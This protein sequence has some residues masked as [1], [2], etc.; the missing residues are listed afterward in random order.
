MVRFL[1]AVQGYRIDKYRRLLAFARRRAG[2]PIRTASVVSA[3]TGTSH[4]APFMAWVAGRIPLIAR[5]LAKPTQMPSCSAALAKL[6]ISVLTPSGSYSARPSRSRISRTRTVVQ[7]PPSPVLQR[8]RFSDTAIR[9]MRGKPAKRVDRRWREIGRVSARP[10]PGH[11]D[12]GVAPSSP[13]DQQHR[14]VGGVVEVADD[15][16]DQDVDQGIAEEALRRIQALYQIES[17]IT[18][19]PCCQPT[20]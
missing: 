3:S 15:L 11:P 13:V 16:L 18:G 19:P 12:L 2:T 9:Q 4:C 1:A 7:V 8:I 14:F 20:G 5:L 10:D 17:H 6:T